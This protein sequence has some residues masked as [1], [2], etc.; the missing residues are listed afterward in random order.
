MNLVPQPV[1]AHVLRDTVEVANIAPADL[2]GLGKAPVVVGL[3]HKIHPVLNPSPIRVTEGAVK[4]GYDP[5]A[6]LRRHGLGRLRSRLRRYRRG[7]DLRLPASD[8]VEHEQR[9]Y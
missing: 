6:G 4:L 8:E 9:N 7:R 1:N 3:G 5:R 2:A